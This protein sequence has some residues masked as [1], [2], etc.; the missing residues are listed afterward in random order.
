MIR[1]NLFQSLLLKEV[2]RRSADATLGIQLYTPGTTVEPV[3]PETPK[4]DSIAPDAADAPD[5][6]DAPAASASDAPADSEW[7]K[8]LNEQSRCQEILMRVKWLDKCPIDDL[9]QFEHSHRLLWQEAARFQEQFDYNAARVCPAEI[10]KNVRLIIAE[11]FW[12]LQHMSNRGW[13]PRT[14]THPHDRHIRE[15]ASQEISPHFTDPGNVVYDLLLHILRLDSYVDVSHVSRV[16]RTVPADY[17][18]TSN[19]S[20]RGTFNLRGNII[21]ALLQDLQKKGTSAST[22]WSWSGESGWRQQ[23]TLQD[24]PI[25]DSS[26]AVKP[27]GKPVNRSNVCFS[28]QTVWSVLAASVLVCSAF[29]VRLC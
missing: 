23:G 26:L 1:K 19:K 2:L 12:T 18:S 4:E 10:F 21:E 6:T 27:W 3:I 20:A 8:W 22:S 14:L 9:T 29:L 7:I 11:T 17:G 16:V 28:D 5:A 15:H 13:L 25:P 24:K